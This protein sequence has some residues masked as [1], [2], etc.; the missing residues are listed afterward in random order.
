MLSR[1]LCDPL[2]LWYTR[3]NGGLI[4]L[5]ADAAQ[6]TLWYLVQVER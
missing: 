6:P 5:T 2:E 4:T 1:V 3:A